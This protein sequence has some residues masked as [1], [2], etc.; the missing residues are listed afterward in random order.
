MKLKLGFKEILNSNLNFLI[1]A[2]DHLKKQNMYI[3]SSLQ[4]I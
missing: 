4:F 3:L 2:F 1:T